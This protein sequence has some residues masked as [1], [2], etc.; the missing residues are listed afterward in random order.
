MMAVTD[1]G[2]VPHQGACLLNGDEESVF[3][4]NKPEHTN[5]NC[6]VLYHVNPS[7][8]LTMKT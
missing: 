6:I 4:V 7:Y 2:W 8:T 3:E 5:S 1:V